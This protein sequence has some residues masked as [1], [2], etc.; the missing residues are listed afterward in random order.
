M[1]PPPKKKKIISYKVQNP[2]ITNEKFIIR[3]CNFWLFRLG[4][5]HEI[6]IWATTL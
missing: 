2:K 1:S 4:E 6:K 5:A 3:T